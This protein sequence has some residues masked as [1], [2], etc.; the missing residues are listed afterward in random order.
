MSIGITT[1]P[2]TATARQGAGVSSLVAATIQA[3]I[4]ALLANLLVHALAGV[5]GIESILIPPGAAPVTITAISIAT[6]TVIPVAIGGLLLILSSRMAPRA[7]RSLPWAGLF[8]GIGTAIMPIS[9]GGELGGRLV[10]AAMHVIT[11]V[12]WFIVVRRI[13]S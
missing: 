8:V 3:A 7:A 11:G 13:K 5:A 6:M 1:H 2:Q 10:L 4:F 12:V 9:M